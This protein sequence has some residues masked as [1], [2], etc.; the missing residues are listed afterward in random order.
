MGQH[1][2]TSSWETRE[3]VIVALTGAPGGD[4]LIRRAA[5]MARRTQ[6][7]PRRC[8]R[9]RAAT[10]SRARCRSCSRATGRLLEELGGSW[11]DVV[12][13]D[14]PATLVAF[15]TAQHAT[16]IVLGTSR[17]SRWT[18]LTRGSI[19][20]RVVREA[21]G[22][23]V[24]VIATDDAPRREGRARPSAPIASAHRRRATRHR[25]RRLRGRDLLVLGALVARNSAL[26]PHHAGAVDVERRPPHVPRRR[27]RRRRDRW[28]DPGG[29]DRV[30]RASL[31]VDWY[32]IPPYRSFAIARGADAA[33]L[34]AFMVTALR[35]GGGR[36]A[37]RDAGASRRCDRA[38]EADVVLALA[39]RLA[40]PNPPQVVVEEIQRH[41]A[42]ALGRAARARRRRLVRS[43]RRSAS[44]RSRRPA[45]VSTTNCATVTCS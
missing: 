21:K 44:P 38:R 23:D 10:G 2:I 39:D 27:R 3:R 14:V 25:V 24:H 41:A 11:H 32:L 15:A 43:R 19:I 34:A 37:G 1:G 29:C 31:V 8:A 45:T 42:P 28:A 26:D 36:R 13:D 17:R 18:E 9:R 7:R 5:R 16:Q 20:N 35:R 40:R 30:G 12:G 33:Y 6:G 22:I 4:D